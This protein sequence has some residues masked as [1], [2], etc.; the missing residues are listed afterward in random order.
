VQVEEQFYILYPLLIALAPPRHLRRLLAVGIVAALFLRIGLA[1]IVPGY[2]RL[3]FA[4][5]PC[6]MENLA[7]GA[8]I[9]S[10]LRPSQWPLRSKTT[11]LLAA[12]G[13]ISRGGLANTIMPDFS[14]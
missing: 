9:A 5:M 7:M 6:R 14:L 12:T 4:L 2:W 8:L 3:Q 11:L 10:Y 1:V 13:L